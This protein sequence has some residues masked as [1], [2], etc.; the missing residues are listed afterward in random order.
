MSNV[1]EDEDSNVEL[2]EYSTVYLVAL[3]TSPMTIPTES[4]VISFALIWRLGV[5]R[6][7]SELIHELPI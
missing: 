1:F 6:V 2:V 5:E 4:A 3:V 7:S